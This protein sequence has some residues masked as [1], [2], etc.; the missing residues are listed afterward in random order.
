MAVLTFYG[1]LNAPLPVFSVKSDPLR[2]FAI[3]EVTTLQV[4]VWEL[5]FWLNYRIPHPLDYRIPHPI[6]Y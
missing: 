4:L 6:N 5:K 2:L 3:G 1:H